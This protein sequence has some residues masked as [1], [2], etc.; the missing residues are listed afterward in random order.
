MLWFQRGR[1]DIDKKSPVNT[2][3]N[4]KASKKREKMLRALVYFF[5]LKNRR[6]MCPHHR[7]GFTLLELLVVIAIIAILAA[8]LLP[9]L[10]SAREKARQ[11]V[12]MSNLKQLGLALIVYAQ[13]YGGYTPIARGWGTSGWRPTLN[14][15]MDIP[16]ETFICPSD[17]RGSNVITSYTYN[18]RIGGDSLGLSPYKLTRVRNPAQVFLLFDDSVPGL[19]EWEAGNHFYFI[20]WCSLRHSGGCNFLFVDNHVSWYAVPETVI[21]ELTWQDIKVEPE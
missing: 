7:K 6:N 11:T 19:H 15:T 3:D 8:M 2:L 1:T 5:S 10:K 12:C 4:A 20:G 21:W 16:L 18:S 14:D 9:A 17:K 13:D